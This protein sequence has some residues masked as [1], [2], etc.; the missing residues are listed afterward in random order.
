MTY[1]AYFRGTR[2]EAK[3]FISRIKSALVGNQRDE[4]GI[5]RAC[6]IAIGFAALSDIKADFVRKSRGGTGEDG[7][8]WK[9]LSKKTLAYSRRFGPGEKTA[10]KQA[11]GLNRGHRFAPVG[12]GLLSAAQLA[13]W[14]RH[15]V[16][17]LSWLQK[18]HSLG[19]AKRIAA[20]IAWNRVKAEGGQTKLEV[21]GNRPHEILR[22]TG[23]LLNS[24]SPGQIGGSGSAYSKPTGDGG[25]DQIF[26][27]LGNGVIV[28]SNVK[29]AA[30]HQDGS[31]KKNIPA[32]PFLP[33]RTPQLWQNKWLKTL[34]R[35]LADG[36]QRALQ[37]GAHA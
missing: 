17:N 8:K 24:L 18:K 27:V 21:F 23:V 28:G 16:S 7:V 12:T 37:G 36:L 14:K 6:F 20:A 30:V 32:R 11:A 15:Y 3:A 22:D 9:P 19:E 26:T 34:E 10:L 33:K 25:P 5:A 13:S 29:Y 31:Q 1:K 35:A 4:T 2:K